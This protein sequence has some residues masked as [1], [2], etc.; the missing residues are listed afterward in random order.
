MNFTEQIVLVLFPTNASLKLSFDVQPNINVR[1]LSWPAHCCY[2][3]LWMNS[4]VERARCTGA[5]SSWSIYWSFG[6]CWVITGQKIVV[7]NLLVFLC[8]NIAFNCCN[9][10]YCVPCNATPNHNYNILVKPL[11][12]WKIA[13]ILAISRVANVLYLFNNVW[14]TYVPSLMIPSLSERFF[15]N[16]TELVCLVMYS[17]F[18]TEVLLMKA[19]HCA[20]K[21]SVDVT[22]NHEDRLG[23]VFGLP[24]VE[25][26]HTRQDGGHKPQT[27][28]D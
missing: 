12:S 11:P 10:A 19:R 20:W 27:S 23:W 22:L 26:S 24:E 3:I 18:H 4:W 1:T 14:T 9:R 25:A 28:T 8:I 15:Y 6:K 2:A 5:L 7:E 13:A 17:F 16:H 21:S